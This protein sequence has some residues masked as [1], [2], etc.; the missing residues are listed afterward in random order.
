MHTAQARKIHEQKL[1]FVYK[2][3][4]RPLGISTWPDDFKLT[5]NT[6]PSSAYLLNKNID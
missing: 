4:R 3:Q 2:M 5:P 1:S 6:I